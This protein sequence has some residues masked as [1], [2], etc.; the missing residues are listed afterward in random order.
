MDRL[1]ACIKKRSA[2]LALCAGMSAFSAHADDLAKSIDADY[3]RSLAALFDDLHRHPELSFAETRTA[4]VL[5]QQLRSAG[6][7]VTEG[8]GGTGIV[9]LLHNGPGPLVMMRTELDGLPVEEKTGLPNASTVV[10]KNAAGADVHVMHACGHDVHMTSI[11]G[12]AHQMA[13]RRAEWSGT[14]MLIGQPAEEVVGGAPAMMK[15]NLWQRFGKPDF[16][17]S[18]HVIGGMESGKVVLEDSPFAGVDSL[19]IIVHGIGTHGAAP[20]FGKDPVVIGAQIVLGLQEIISRE[21]SPRDSAVITVGSFHAGT[22]SNII[23]DSA[24]M[25][26]SVRSLRPDVRDHLL[27]AISRVAINTA[28][29]A[30]V[31]ENLLPEIRTI[32]DPAAPVVNDPALMKRVT[33]AWQQHI[34][35]DIYDPNYRNLTMGA[36]DFGAFTTDPYIP[37]VY[38]EIGATPKQDLE[39]SRRTGTPVPV[40]HSPLFKADSSTAIKSGV[41]FTVVALMDLL[42]KQ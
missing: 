33:A 15:D 29:A 23:G 13:T 24:R 1:P 41:Q 36:E 12:V 9:A 35:K 28:R 42:K 26:L 32:H 4:K 21:I 7:E 20:S 34:G 17:L 37:S 22:K 14:L 30:G 2:I 40:N 25:E 27:K 18:L 16:A 8:V 6:F 5:A 11:V 31:P 10:V 39:E 19:E 38:F 3:Q